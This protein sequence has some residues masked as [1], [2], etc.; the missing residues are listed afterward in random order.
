MSK[1]YHS[2]VEED[3]P[4]NLAGILFFELIWAIGFGFAIYTVTVPAYLTLVKASKLL[5]GLL[6]SAFTIFIILQ[7]IS[8]Y[9]FG[10]L[11]RKKFVIL[12][13]A[14]AGLMYVLAGALCFLWPEPV[15]RWLSVGLFS[16]CMLAFAILISF[17][18]PLYVELSVDIAPPRKRGL[19]FG[20]I[21]MILGGVGLPFSFLASRLGKLSST[22]KSY[23]LRFLAA[24]ILFSLSTLGV[25]L[26]RDHFNPAHAGNFRRTSVI[27]RVRQV[28]L[29]VL[30][31]EKYA[32]FIFFYTSL[33][34]A[35]NL[36][37]SYLIPYAREELKL[38]ERFM[39]FFPRAWLLSGLLFC[40][41]IG[42]VGDRYG[43]RWVGRILSG[44]VLA[45]CMLILL[46]PLPGILLLA[47]L[48]FSLG[49]QLAIMLLINMGVELCPEI[50][51]ATLFAV[52]SLVP[53]P[54]I[55]SLVTL[56]GHL[57]DL[58]GNY[59]GILV[60]TTALALVAT[61]GFITL[62]REPREHLPV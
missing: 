61:A 25:L 8:S 58:T 29:R 1:S 5:I 55:L 31:D 46:W 40:V 12:F 44:S 38:P 62:V 14:S 9:Y 7:I 48:F 6:Q 13:H 35:V 34:V 22:L 33:V 17:G 54:F 52:T 36:G 24:G 53:L 51:P 3:F 59:R 32:V 10:G 11:R 50:P 45:G 18:T 37:I 21:Y 49:N 2:L 15:P 47:Y 16:A 19:L 57:I 60:L 4:R 23:S 28:L 30:K 42:K 20:F 41:P 26:I 56:A 27:Q 39:D 43:Y